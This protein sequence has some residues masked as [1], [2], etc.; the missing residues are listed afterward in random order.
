MG[1]RAIREA[2]ERAVT[3][4]LDDGVY[5]VSCHG[6]DDEQGFMPDEEE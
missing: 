5:S 2:L 6:Q 4:R 1:T 3:Y